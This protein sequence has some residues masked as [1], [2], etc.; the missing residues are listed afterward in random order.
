MET[1]VGFSS[2]IITAVAESFLEV[3]ERESLI[4]S[5]ATEATFSVMLS[6]RELLCS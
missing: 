6:D 2:V 4:A 3:V 5:F 1:T